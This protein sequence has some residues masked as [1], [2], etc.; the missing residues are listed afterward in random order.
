M[1]LGVPLDHS[2]P[3]LL[4]AQLL[5]LET[6]QKPTLAKSLMSM[7]ST[8]LLVFHVT[9]SGCLNKLFHLVKVGIEVHAMNPSSF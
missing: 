3:G 6:E 8:P 9:Y 5:I 4:K 2:Y 1:L 7:D